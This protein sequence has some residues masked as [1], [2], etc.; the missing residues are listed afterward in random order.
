MADTILVSRVLVPLDGSV[1]ARRALEPALRIARCAHCPLELLTV[2]DPVYGRWAGD[3]DEIADTLDY[4]HVDVVAVGSGWSGDV[5]VEEANERF[6]SIVCM[7]SHQR[8]Q[9]DRLILGSVSAHVIRNVAEPV[10]LVGPG[11]RAESADTPYRSL[12]VCL[13][14]SPRNDAA[15]DLARAWATL[16]STE[17]EFV[18]VASPA[19]D[20]LALDVLDA[21]L[22]RSAASL[23]NEKIEATHT[24]L[25]DDNP[26]TRIAELLA[27]REGAIALTATHGRTGLT[28]MLMGS[29]T[30]ELLAL[31]PA[32]VLITRAP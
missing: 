21:D 28:R 32:P 8:G 10:L 23:S 1:E 26:A 29:M 27:A 12:V 17:V 16:T 30:A 20:Q 19:E 24:L 5:I 25:V 3:L 31:S 2:Y 4:E 22:A 14:G 7:T 6:G 11:Y 13:D 18:H 9:L 15:M